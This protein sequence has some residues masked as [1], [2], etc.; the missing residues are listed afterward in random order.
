MTQAKI[1][2]SRTEAENESLRIYA[3][4]MND[5][6]CHYRAEM[7]ELIGR[8]RLWQ[9]SSN[10]YEIRNFYIQAEGRA[11]RDHINRVLRIYRETGRDLQ[12]MR[13]R[14]NKAGDVS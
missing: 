6:S 4:H 1:N 2:D 14:I 8:Y 7:R 3:D 10:I 12:A 11:M 5:L 13:R 9:R